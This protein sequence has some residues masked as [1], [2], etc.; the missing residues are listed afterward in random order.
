MD[1]ALLGVFGYFFIRG[2][3]RGFLLELFDL[4]ALLAGYLLARLLA[5]VGGQLLANSTGMSRWLA[6]ILAAIALFAIGVII[7]R[8]AARVIRKAAHSLSLAGFD[9]ALGATFGAMKAFLF[10]MIFFLLLSLTPW[11]RSIGEYAARGQFSS[12]MWLVSQVVR[13]TADIEPVAPTQAMAKWLRAAGMNEEVVHII[14]DRPELMAALLEQARTGGRLDLPVDQILR[15]E[16]ALRMPDMKL[17]LAPGQQDS[18]VSL[19]E[20]MD[21]S[22][23]EKAQRFWAQLNRGGAILE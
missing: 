16:P 9:R 7:M 1:W 3:F 23:T 17:D 15:G 5:P 10:A 20:N 12:W 11:A 21:M 14:T 19:L 8:I 6:G 22:N 4:L 13:E 2:L 18:L